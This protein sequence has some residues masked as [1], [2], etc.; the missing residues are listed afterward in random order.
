MATTS[1]VTEKCINDAVLKELNKFED[2]MTNRI[3]NKHTA[4]VPS[5]SKAYESVADNTKKYFCI[6]EKNNTFAL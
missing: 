1:R 4:H 3:Q 6:R 2:W 5:M